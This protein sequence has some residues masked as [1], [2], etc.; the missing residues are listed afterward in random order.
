MPTPKHIVFRCVRLSTG[1]SRG[2][3]RVRHDFVSRGRLREASLGGE[4]GTITKLAGGMPNHCS[5][6]TPANALGPD[7]AASAIE[8]IDIERQTKGR[9][10]CSPS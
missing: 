5:T 8:P 1:A 2:S 10:G 6:A 7:F 3:D 4:T 9:G